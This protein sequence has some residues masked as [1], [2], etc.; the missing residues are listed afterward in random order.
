MVKVTQ[1]LGKGKILD[2][3]VTW[4][5]GIYHR[6]TRFAPILGIFLF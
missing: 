3:G 1:L 4:C 2:Y 5:N 6:T